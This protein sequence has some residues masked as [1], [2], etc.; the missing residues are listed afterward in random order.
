VFFIELKDFTIF[1]LNYFPFYV[2]SSFPLYVQLISNDGRIEPLQ[3]LMVLN[4]L[5]L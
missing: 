4:M 2:W 5:V 3:T 1:L